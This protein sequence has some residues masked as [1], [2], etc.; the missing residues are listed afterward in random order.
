MDD[1]RPG[2]IQLLF[3]WTARFQGGGID[4]GGD[5]DLASSRKSDGCARRFGLSFSGEIR[6]VAAPWADRTAARARSVPGL[7]R[8]VQSPGAGDACRSIGAYPGRGDGRD[9]R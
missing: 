2:P 7:R 1:E 3:G 4:A 5:C 9:G 6:M 8:A